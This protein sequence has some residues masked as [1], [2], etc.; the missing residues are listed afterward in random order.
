MGSSVRDRSRYGE[1]SEMRRGGE[2]FWCTENIGVWR[3]A[4]C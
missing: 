1:K 3:I 2:E 4:S